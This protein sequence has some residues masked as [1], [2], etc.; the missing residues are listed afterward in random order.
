MRHAGCLTCNEDNLR[1]RD[2]LRVGSLS[3][4]GINL[5]QFLRLNQAMAATAVKPQSR[6]KAQ[7]CILLWLEGGPS[8][9]DTWD[10]KPN[11]PF[12]PIS[13][14]VAGIQVSE[15][16]PRVAKR[17]DKLSII[18]TMVTEENN[19][20]QASY[21]AMTGHRPNPAMELRGPSC[22]SA[23]RQ[24][25]LIRRVVFPLSDCRWAITASRSRNTEEAQMRSFPASPT[26]ASTAPIRGQPP[27][28][29]SCLV[30]LR[31]AARFDR[32]LRPERP[33]A[34]SRIRSGMR[35]GWRM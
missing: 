20:P 14:N 12:R 13:T 9:M 3:L 30:L 22:D 31:S 34:G 32:E 35:E 2:F 10:P 26:S 1:R 16:L 28:R 21:Y 27:S 25:S 29:S 7:A 8:Q 11:S 6:P 19:H 4:L 18:R 33:S 24:Q 5:G 17:M 23:R 15:L